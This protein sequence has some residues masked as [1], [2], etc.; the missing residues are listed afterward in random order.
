MAFAQLMGIGG[1]SIISRSLGAGDKPKANRT[2]GN[3]F[4]V[5]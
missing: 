1:A 4:T 5:V 3:I 2:A